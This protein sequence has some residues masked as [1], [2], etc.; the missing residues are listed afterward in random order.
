MCV[1]EQ[2]AP[3]PKNDKYGAISKRFKETSPAHI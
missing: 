3:P 2:A 1:P